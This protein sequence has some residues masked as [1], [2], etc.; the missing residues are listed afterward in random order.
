MV[1]TSGRP[2]TKSTKIPKWTKIDPDPQILTLASNLVTCPIHSLTKIWPGS[3]HLRGP[4]PPQTLA[5][6]Q[7]AQILTSNQNP[8][9]SRTSLDP[10]NLTWTPN[11]DSWPQIWPL[12]PKWPKSDP[13]PL[14][15]TSVPDLPRPCQ[16][17]AAFAGPFHH[18][19]PRTP[20]WPKKSTKMTKM[21]QIWSK[22]TNHQSKCQNGPK[23]PKSWKTDLRT[24]WADPSR[25][26]SSQPKLRFQKNFSQILKSKIPK[27]SKCQKIQIS[28]LRPS[29]HTI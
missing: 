7:N 29:G 21:T 13:E 6:S 14:P 12:R 28:I 19:T 8:D 17:W 18:P 2:G 23:W 11:F 3:S 26:N 1:L 20:S 27:L 10:K 16:A 15:Q 25:D 9:P 4:R 22:R 5:K 24:S